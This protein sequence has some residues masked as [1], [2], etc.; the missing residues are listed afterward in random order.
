MN[1][2]K[3]LKLFI[4]IISEDVARLV[5]VL[6][7][8][9][10]DVLRLQGCLILRVHIG[11][12]NLI[13]V[14]EK[15]VLRDGHVAVIPYR[16]ACLMVAEY[17]VLRYLREA[18]P[19]D[20]NATSLILVDFIVGNEVA[21]VEENDAVTVVVN[22]IVLD[23]AEARLD[24]EDSLRT[25]L[26]DQVVKDHRVSRVV[27]AVG[28]VGFVVLEYL[29]LLN[30]CRCGVDEQNSLPIV[31]ADT[32]I[33]YFYARSFACTDA[34]FTIVA[35]VVIL[36]DARIVLLTLNL[37]ACL[38]VLLEPIITDNSIR[39]ETVLG[40]NN[41]AVLTILTNFVHHYVRISTQRLNT[42][43]TICDV[44]QLDLG[45]GSTLNLDA[46]AVDVVYLTAEHLRF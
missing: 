38:Q 41:N 6:T 15:V 28:Y 23:P 1:S 10:Y 35:D 18:I 42:I 8:A 44:A 4:I 29:V 13:E 30:I 31:R 26:V 9:L 3:F 11:H 5:H 14:V 34:G 21:T 32:V 33:K 7:I 20:N 40:G 39:A 19:A 46:W 16:D 2:L 25:R 24:A 36:L 22:H 27:S 17:S 37:N 45:A 43:G 12:A